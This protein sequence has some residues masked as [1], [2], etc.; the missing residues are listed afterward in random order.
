[1]PATTRYRIPSLKYQ[2]IRLTGNACAG[3]GGEAN[4]FRETRMPLI[5][6]DVSAAENILAF[7]EMIFMRGEGIDL[8]VPAEHK[9]DWDDRPSRVRLYRDRQRI[10]LAGPATLNRRFQATQGTD[11]EPSMATLAIMLYLMSSPLSRK[12][13]ITWNADIPQVG[14]LAQ[15]YGRGAASGG[16]LYPA[17]LYVVAGSGEQ[18]GEGVYHYSSAQHALVPV[19]FG[20]W[21]EQLAHA[22]AEQ[23]EEGVF[24]YYVIISVDFWTNCFKYHNFGYHVCS[25]DAGVMLGALEL[26][27][28]AL[29]IAQRSFLAFDDA[30]V[31]QA[32]GAD[33]RSESA[34]VVVGLGNARTAAPA[35]ADHAGDDQCPPSPARAWNRSRSVKIP[36]DLIDVHQLTMMGPD[37]VASCVAALTQPAKAPKSSAT[38][39]VLDSRVRAG[40]PSILLARRSAWG[41]LNGGAAVDKEDL[42]ALLDFVWQHAVSGANSVREPIPPG[43][44]GLCVRVNAVGDLGRGAYHWDGQERCLVPMPSEDLK[45]WQSTYSMGNYNIDE[46]G[47]I[48]FVTGNLPSLVEQYGSRGYRILNAYVGRIAQFAYV[49]AA[50]LKLDCGAVLGVRAKLVKRVMQLG[51][52]ENVCIG[53]Y[54]SKPQDPQHLFDFSL[55]PDVPAWKR[56]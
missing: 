22:V 4:D 56:A 27:C 20:A 6:K 16:G 14:Y 36:P 10:P 52:N 8:M 18:P 29:G 33:G 53:F 25:Q 39:P 44:V 19:R 11:N 49:A 41:S 40:L 9:P 55:V 3:D 23:G 37:Q 13:D 54:V 46:V 26:A 17:Q 42:L 32:V 24:P 35:L 2:A 31:N 50:A 47:C 15:E 28:D 21:T 30:T 48:L 7:S 5:R 45:T 51:E 12:L 1:M 43:S 38:Q 34:F